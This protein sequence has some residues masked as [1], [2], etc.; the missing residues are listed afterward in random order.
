M[1][2]YMV[3]MDHRH[4][5]GENHWGKTRGKGNERV[6]E[7]GATHTQNGSEKDPCGGVPQKQKRQGRLRPLKSVRKSLD[8]TGKG[9]GEMGEKNK[10]STDEGV[11][12]IEGRWCD[13]HR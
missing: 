11:P 8:R 12:G 4:V 3:S 9:V 7:L 2:S 5:I 13:N 1:G 10:R 6:M